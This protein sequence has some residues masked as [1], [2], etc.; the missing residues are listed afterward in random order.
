[1]GKKEWIASILEKQKGEGFDSENPIVYG[2]LSYAP[3]GVCFVVHTLSSN[4]SI[5]VV[6]ILG[7]NIPS[8][9]EDCL[10]KIIE[11]KD[12]GLYAFQL[13]SITGADFSF[14]IETEENFRLSDARKRE[15]DI[16]SYLSE[17]SSWDKKDVQ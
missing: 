2:T 10:V 3:T 16:Q 8:I 6:S 13:Q 9:L 15:L 14:D 7:N 17:Y 11:D 4:A 12:I 5:A 1:M